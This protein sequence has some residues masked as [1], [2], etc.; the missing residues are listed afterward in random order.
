ML[1]LATGLH[2]DEIVSLVLQPRIMG[3]KDAH[4]GDNDNAG[5]ATGVGDARQT[6]AGRG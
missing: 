1:M 2:E 6:S 4:D 3:H 5:H